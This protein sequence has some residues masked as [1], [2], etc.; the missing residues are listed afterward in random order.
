MDF[1]STQ[2]SLS[3]LHKTDNFLQEEDI[4]CYPIWID[5]ATLYC[6]ANSIHTQAGLDHK[7]HRNLN[8]TSTL[9]QVTEATM[10]RAHRVAFIVTA[11]TTFY[12]L[13]FFQILSV[14]LVDDD[15]VQEILPVVSKLLWQ[16]K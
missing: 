9:N 4:D 8:Q 14:P 5:L 1:E 6:E 2:F 13:A 16:I 7:P 10:A 11:F 15:I 12:L 3:R